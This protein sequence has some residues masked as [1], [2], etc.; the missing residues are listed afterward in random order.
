MRRM[1]W[2]SLG[3]AAVLLAACNGGNSGGTYTPG[4]PCGPPVGN[5]VVLAYPAPGATAVPDNFG[6]VV[7]ASATA[8]PSSYQAVVLNTTTQNSVT[9]NSVQPAPNPL[10]SPIATPPFANPIYQASGN[11]G[12]TFVSGSTINVYLNNTA[13]TCVPTNSL[14]SFT[15]Q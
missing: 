10:P 3:A 11:P 2:A 9:F 13:S 4:G 12:A 14:G 1:M 8:L 7:L 5:S 15:V 6:L